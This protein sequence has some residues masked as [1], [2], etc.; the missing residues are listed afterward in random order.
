MQIADQPDDCDGKRD[1]EKKK[2]DLAFS[3]LL[4]Q[5][6]RTPGTSPFAYEARALSRDCD[7]ESFITS[8]IFGI[9]FRP[10]FLDY[11]HLCNKPL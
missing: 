4:A 2:N 5:R 8:I 1:H 9:L 11:G 10:A 3:S 6:T 7:A